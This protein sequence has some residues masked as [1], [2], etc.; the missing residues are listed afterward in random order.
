MTLPRLRGSF[1][2]GAVPAAHQDL[3]VLLPSLGTTSE[4]WDGVVARLRADPVT[5]T[6]RVLRVDLPGHGAS[7]PAHDPF[8]VADLAEAVLAVVDEAGGGSFHAAGVSLGGAVALELAAT[9]PARVRTLTMCCSGARIGTPEGWAERAAGVRSS[10]TASLVAASA[11]RWFAPGFPA[12][13]QRAAARALDALIGVDDESYA[14]CAEALARFD[15]W[16]ESAGSGGPATISVP[17]LLVSGGHDAV[18]P[19]ASMDEL[20]QALPHAVHVTI[21]SAGH[22]APLET[23]ADVAALV[24]DHLA[25][26]ADGDAR[27]ARARGMQVRRAV[28]G[29]AH[30]DAA[31]AATTPLTAAFQD[32]LTRYAW[33]EVWD[34]PVLSRRERS[35]A[36]LATL[37]TGGHVEEL[38]MHVHAAVRNGL[39]PDEVAEVVLHTALYAGLPSANTAM[40]V[41]REAF[42]PTDHAATDTDTDTDEQGGG[43]GQE[44]RDG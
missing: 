32:L 14:R 16:A 13:D 1:A 24:R 42:A 19:P 15:R 35:I 17:T 3:L 36:T 25:V 8:T 30:V 2:P 26:S 40:A 22:L 23:P 10:G 21:A 33:G 4:V 28:L 18:T 11:A 9:H 31:V 29:D 12:R 27:E 41:V 44:R 37:V 43:H 34:R 5:A 20:A 7:P 6:L 39:R 38:R